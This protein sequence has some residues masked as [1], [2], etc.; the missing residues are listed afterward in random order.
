[1]K[2]IQILHVYDIKAINNTFKSHLQIIFILAECDFSWTLKGESTICCFF[3]MLKCVY[4]FLGITTLNYQQ[5]LLEPQKAPETCKHT[6]MW[7]NG[8]VTL[9]R[10]SFEFQTLLFFTK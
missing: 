6:L 2:T 8:G 7:K 5:L 9:K 3:L 1:M 4:M 10:T